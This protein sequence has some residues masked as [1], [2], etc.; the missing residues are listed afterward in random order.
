MIYI[1]EDDENIG[2]M[3][4]YAL[5]NSGFG[6]ELFEDSESF[7]SAVA[8]R[9]PTLVILDLMLPGEDG[10]TILRRLRDSAETRKIPIIIVAARTERGRLP[11][12]I[13]MEIML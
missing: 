9:L 11:C 3:E 13:R 5:K 7:F 10:L 8:R 4:C 2:Q 1:V 6:T 12:L